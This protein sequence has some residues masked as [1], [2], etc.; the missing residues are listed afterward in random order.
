M[1]NKLNHHLLHHHN[2]FSLTQLHS[3]IPRSSVSHTHAQEVHG[4][5]GMWGYCEY[6]TVPLCL[7]FLLTF[8]PAPVWLLSMDCNSSPWAPVPD[9]RTCSS[10][11][12]SRATVPV[13][14]ICYGMGATPAR[15]TLYSV[16]SPGPKF[17][18]GEPG[19]PPALHGHGSCQE[20]SALAWAVHSQSSSKRSQLQHGLSRM[21]FPVRKTLLQHGLPMATIP[22]RR[23]CSSV[24]S[25]QPAVS[26]RKNLLW[27]GLSMV[28]VPVRRMSYSM[29]T[30]SV[31]RTCSS[32]GSTLATVPVR[33]NLL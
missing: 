12:S 6:I 2:F 22:I 30:D 26:V 1:R 31:R 29:G 16:C 14:R 19:P 32:V 25:P 33:K 10:M 24:G 20:K 3:I 18:S 13:R 23:I 28:T 11:C 21:K 27:R 17:L 5:W 4:R 9:R 15:T 7:S 8:F